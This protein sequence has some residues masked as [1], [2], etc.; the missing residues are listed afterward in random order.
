MKTNQGEFVLDN[1]H[2]EV[3]PWND[4]R[5]A[6]VKRQSQTDQ[7]VWVDIGEPTAAPQIV[8]R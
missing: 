2:D 4:T 7:N 3:K 6:Y 8:S 1:L 5:Y